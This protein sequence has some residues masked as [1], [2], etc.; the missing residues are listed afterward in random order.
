[1]DRVTDSQLFKILKNI[2]RATIILCFREFVIDMKLMKDGSVIMA[3]TNERIETESKEDI[4]KKYTNMMESKNISFHFLSSMISIIFMYILMCSNS[5]SHVK[6]NEND[7]THRW[8]VYGY[9]HIY[10][11]FPSAMLWYTLNASTLKVDVQFNNTLNMMKLSCLSILCTISYILL[12]FSGRSSS[13]LSVFDIIYI[14]AVCHNLY[15]SI[16]QHGIILYTSKNH[17]IHSRYI[18]ELS[19]WRWD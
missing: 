17:R 3:R 7:A 9:S 15:A 1:M 5:T 2:L 8:N 13:Q 11:L 12:L 6:H 4:E 18:S 10:L 14:S 16:H 19:M